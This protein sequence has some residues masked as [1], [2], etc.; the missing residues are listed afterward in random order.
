MLLLN[1]LSSTSP[2]FGLC[3]PN[4]S[5]GND[6]WNLNIFLPLSITGV[7]CGTPSEKKFLKLIPVFWVF[8]LGFWLVYLN[9]RAHFGL[10]L[11]ADF[12]YMVYEAAGKSM[13]ILIFFLNI[14]L[15][16]WNLRTTF[17][18]TWNFPPSCTLSLFKYNWVNQVIRGSAEMW[19]RTWLLCVEN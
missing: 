19:G 14:S 13:W 18:F 6:T 17:F 9:A 4:L 12:W 5:S 16:G 15:S 10:E 11:L 2:K 3:V 1:H 8:F 7:S